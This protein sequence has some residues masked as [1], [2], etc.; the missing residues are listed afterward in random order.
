MVFVI[1]IMHLGPLLLAEL[2]KTPKW[3]VARSLY[4]SESKH[5]LLSRI[6]KM[7]QIWQKCAWICVF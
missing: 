7:H 1:R 2:K 5:L 3:L 4:V 6:G